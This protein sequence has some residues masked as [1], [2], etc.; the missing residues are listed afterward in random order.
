MGKNCGDVDL[1][2][3]KTKNCGSCENATQYC[4]N[5]VCK[6]CSSNICL[7]KFPNGGLAVICDG[8]D[9][10]TCD[11]DSNTGCE[12]VKGRSKCDNG[13]KDGKCIQCGGKGQACCEGNRCNSGLKCVSNKCVDSPKCGDGICESSERCNCPQDC[14]DPC[15]GIHCGTDPYGCNK[16]CGSKCDECEI[17]D[18]GQCK[19]AHAVLHIRS[20]TQ[21]CPHTSGS[22]ACVKNNTVTHEIYALVNGTSN[23]VVCVYTRKEGDDWGVPNCKD[24]ETGRYI[25]KCF[26]GSFKWNDDGRE[27]Q[28]YVYARCKNQPDVDPEN[29]CKSGKPCYSHR[30]VIEGKDNCKKSPK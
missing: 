2:C 9:V 1:G 10:V 15:K 11:E 19:P 16:T 13:C 22:D 25:R 27:M 6:A 30:S 14:G 26:T 12:I 8:N 23:P 18:A 3:G 20:W 21:G 7:E 29:N 24:W 5:G 17:C 28:L 4:D